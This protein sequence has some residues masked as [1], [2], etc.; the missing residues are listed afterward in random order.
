MAENSGVNLEGNAT[1]PLELGGVLIPGY[2]AYAIT[3]DGKVWSR[4]VRGGSGKRFLGTKWNQ[5]IPFV[6]SR[7]HLRVELYEN[8]KP[9]KFLVHRLVLDAFCG[10]CPVGL[11]C[12]HR[13]GNPKNNR[14]DNLRWDTAVANWR[15][16]RLHGRATVGMRQSQA[17]LTDSDV[18][19]IRKIRAD[20]KLLKTIAEMFDVSIATIGRITTG[21]NWTHVNG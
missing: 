21:K 5:K 1:S 15:D 13:D 12:C 4:H 2:P 10:P 8:G 20:G 11:E 16:K 7:G 6:S 9:R 17:K 3:R 18:V 14:I 19:L